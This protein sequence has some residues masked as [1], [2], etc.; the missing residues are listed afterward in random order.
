MN[1]KTNIDLLGSNEL[2]KSNITSLALRLLEPFENGE[3]TAIEMD[4]QLKF[5]EETIKKSREKINGFVLA[6]NIAKGTEIQGCKI[7]T[8]EGY[9]Q[10]NYEEDCK[11]YVL[12]EQLAYRKQELDNS[13]KTKHEVVDLETGEII[14]K[15]SV[16]GYTKDSVSYTFKK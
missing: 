15:V 7:A 6:S 9:A 10:L 8:K 4:M 12:K 1:N 14:P 3:K 2:S 5:V 11:Y 16:K 13:F